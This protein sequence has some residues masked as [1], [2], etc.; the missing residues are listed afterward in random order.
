[1]WVHATKKGDHAA[2]KR[3]YAAKT[4]WNSF[5]NG[6]LLT[7]LLLSSLKLANVANTL[8]GKDQTGAM[9]VTIAVMIPADDGLTLKVE[10]RGNLYGVMPGEGGNA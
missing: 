3:R 5:N 2:K 7:L 4:S 1:M 9:I 6:F 10:K 8:A